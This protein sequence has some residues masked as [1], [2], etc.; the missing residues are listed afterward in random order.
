MPL[1]RSESQP[2]TKAWNGLTI[3]GKMTR[4]HQVRP[5]LLLVTASN[6]RE[7]QFKTVSNG[8]YQEL[9]RLMSAISWRAIE[10]F[11]SLFQSTVGPRL[12]YSV[13]VRSPFLMKDVW[14]DS[15]A[16]NTNARRASKDELSYKFG[17]YEPFSLEKSR[18]SRDMIRRFIPS[19]GLRTVNA[20]E[21]FV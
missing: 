4:F 1:D 13:Q 19:K 20:E 15:K 10:I 8:A 7:A 6:K 17:R 18:T 16:S 3:T 14:K 5:T 2:L 11:I 21:R 12:K 9:F